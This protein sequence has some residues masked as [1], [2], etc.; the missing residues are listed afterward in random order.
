[1]PFVEV[2]VEALDGPAPWDGKAMGELMVRGPFIASAYFKNPAEASKFTEDGWFRTGDIVTTSPEG[3]VRITDRSKDLIK[4]GGEWISSVDLENALIGH[5]AIAEAA[6]VAVAHPKWDERPVACV[7]LRPGATATPE[8]LRDFLAPKFA[9][10]WLP[11]AYLFM[12]AI[13]RTATGKFM[14]MALRQQLKDFRWS[15]G[16]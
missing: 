1:M 9:K 8:E 7:V 11:D 4:S 6:V 2:R 14:K 15:G 10:F 16:E 12:E 5:P 13:P 3:Y